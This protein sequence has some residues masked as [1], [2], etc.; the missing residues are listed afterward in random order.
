MKT[1]KWTPQINLG[2]WRKLVTIN[3]IHSINLSSKKK[4][5]KFQVLSQW[6][7][8]VIVHREH[9]WEQADCTS[10]PYLACAKGQNLDRLEFVKLD[11]DDGIDTT[12]WYIHLCIF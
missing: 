11:D 9:A 6:L 1:K 3:L 7:D 2:E 5:H 4:M 10:R 8:F 12:Q